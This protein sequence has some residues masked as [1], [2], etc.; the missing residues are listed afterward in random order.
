MV[1][2]A[3]GQVSLQVLTFSRVIVIPAVLLSFQQYSMLVNCPVTDAVHGMLATDS[4]SAGFQCC[5]EHSFHSIVQ[6]RQA[7]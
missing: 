1:E 7:N 5:F 3:P 4:V 6:N 2:G